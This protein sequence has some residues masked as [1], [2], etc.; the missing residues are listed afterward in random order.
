MPK[1]APR[2]SGL[3]EGAEGLGFCF[4]CARARA[5]P[6]RLSRLSEPCLRVACLFRPG[7]IY[8]RIYSC[9]RRDVFLEN[10]KA[11]W[12]LEESSELRLSLPPLH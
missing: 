10:K 6:P 11:R 4:V 9:C 12:L 3:V 8:P 2:S 5:P 7:H 1:P